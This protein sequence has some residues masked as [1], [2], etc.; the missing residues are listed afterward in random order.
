MEAFGW[1]DSPS[2]IIVSALPYGLL[3]SDFSAREWFF[4]AEGDTFLGKTIRRDVCKYS[5]E[6]LAVVLL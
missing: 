2:R 5:S 4:V 3:A 1:E 6:K